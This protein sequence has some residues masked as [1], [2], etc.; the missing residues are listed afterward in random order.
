MPDNTGN[1]LL[2]AA[3]STQTVSSNQLAGTAAALFKTFT[4]DLYLDRVVRTSRSIR[5]A[6]QPAHEVVGTARHKDG[7]AAA[8]YLVLVADGGGHLQLV[9]TCRLDDES[10]YLPAFR[11]MVENLSLPRQ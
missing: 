6:G 5:I 3:A 2:V 1:P 9:G 8:L 4:P 11:Q 7:Y 10:K